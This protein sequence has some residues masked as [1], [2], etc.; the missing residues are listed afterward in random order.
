[1]AGAGGCVRVVVLADIH[2]NLPAFEAVLDRVV[3]ISPCV[4]SLK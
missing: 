4:E 1:L 2:D 3:D